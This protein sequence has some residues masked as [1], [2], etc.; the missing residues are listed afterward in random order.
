MKK[1]TFAGKES[2]NTKMQSKLGIAT[3]LLRSL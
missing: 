3:R 2:S 1:H